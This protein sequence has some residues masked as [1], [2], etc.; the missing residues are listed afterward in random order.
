[1]SLNNFGQ[2]IMNNLQKHLPS[3]GQQPR[4][5]DEEV[6]AENIQVSKSE[7]GLV[8]YRFTYSCPNCKHRHK[9]KE[10]SPRFFSRV[11]YALRCGFVKIRM[12]WATEKAAA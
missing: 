8:T 12:P 7:S 1:M 2:E 10:I 4:I 6:I 9:A 5:P 11:G 3:G